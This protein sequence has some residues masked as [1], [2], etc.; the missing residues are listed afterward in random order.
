MSVAH[1][2]GV[3]IRM[4]GGGEYEGCAIEVIGSVVVLY[5]LDAPR[6]II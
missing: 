2:L 5:M 1:D 4:I 3:Y 6:K